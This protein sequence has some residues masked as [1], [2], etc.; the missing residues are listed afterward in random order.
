MKNLLV[1]LWLSLSLFRAS[2]QSDTI[3][4]LPDSLRRNSPD[5]NSWYNNELPKDIGPAKDSLLLTAQQIPDNI[6]QAMDAKEEL[7]GWRDGSVYQDRVNKTFKIFIK[8]KRNVELF[9]M[10]SDGQIVSY[11]SYIPKQ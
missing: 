7:K 1:F 8:R 10:S 3:P 9:V 4:T 2:A 6:K 11:R 5:P